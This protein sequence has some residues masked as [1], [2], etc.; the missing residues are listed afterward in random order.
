MKKYF[1]LVV[2]FALTAYVYG[3][4]AGTQNGP[5]VTFEK[6]THDFGDI[7]HGDKVEHVFKFTNTG[8]E[9]L[10]ITNVEVQCGCTTPKWPKEPIPPGAQGELVVGFDSRGKNG[11]QVKT[12]TLVSNAINAEGKKVSFTTNVLPKKDPQP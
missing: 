7:T 4:Q 9:P 8:N 1:L 5:V 3:Q 2:A 10:L 6:S 12:V 11:A